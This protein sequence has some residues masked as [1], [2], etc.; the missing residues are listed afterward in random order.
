MTTI[1]YLADPKTAAGVDSGDTGYQIG[2]IL[3]KASDPNTWEVA[4]FYKVM[5]TD[6]TIADIAD[7]DFGDGGLDRRGH[8]VWAAYNF[9]KYLQLK[10]KFFNTKR[11][12]QTGDPSTK[13]DIDRFQ[14][15]LVMKF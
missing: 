6:A 3:G 7:S 14:V 12:S 10:T 9:T 8:I 5:E 13:D 1:A 11:E 15:N 4:Y 2:L